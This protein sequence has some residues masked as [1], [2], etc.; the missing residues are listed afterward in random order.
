MINKTTVKKIKNNTTLI[1]TRKAGDPFV[2]ITYGFKVGSVN[3]SDDIRGI[4]HFIE[5]M[6]FNGTKKFLKEQ[7]SSLPECY[8]GSVNANT[9]KNVTQY[10]I[11][12]LK[13]YMNEGIELVN[14]L[15]FHPLFPEQYLK[16]E[17][18]IVIQEIKDS[19][20]NHWHIV[21]N[22]SDGLFH[23]SNLQYPILGFENIIENLTRDELINYHS[24]F[25]IP[26]NCVISICGDI[27]EDLLVR[28]IESYLPDNNT[29]LVDDIPD[30]IS[31]SSDFV[32]TEKSGITQCK[33][34]KCI[35]FPNSQKSKFIVLSHILGGSMNSR[36]FDELREKQGLCYQVGC[37]VSNHTQEY[38]Q[39]YMYISYED[40][41]KT[42]H[43]IAEM[44]RIVLEILKEKPITDNEM[45]QAKSFIQGHTYRSNEKSSFIST[46]KVRKFVF[47]DILNSE[48]SMNKLQAVTVDDMA[49]VIKENYKN[50][51][52][53]I[54]K[55]LK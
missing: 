22:S 34:M 8:G 6:C 20:D 46:N 26:S 14:D 5:H 25:Y 21:F 50:T 48:D 4:S 53:A 28:T 12:V 43:I 27:D 31:R 33:L 13:E 9:C 7:I 16:K 54:L 47:N 38:S 10:E 29:V 51:F 36:L 39:F 2:S 1:Y 17:K 42:E 32:I 41:S 45:K 49:D 52:N 40:E 15:V 19:E 35:L 23:K 30:D 24:K 37:G 44:D 11:Q 18:N 3:E 55:P